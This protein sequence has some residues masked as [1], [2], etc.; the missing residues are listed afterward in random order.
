MTNRP[1]LNALRTFEAAV[2]RG[3]F[4]AAAAELLLTPS[5]VSR[6]IQL[7]EMQLG[8][9]LFRRIGRS[10]AATD[11]GQAYYREI[12]A[13]FGRITAAT[14]NITG[15]G[16]SER[17]SVHSAPS[18]ATQWLLPRL[19]QFVSAHPEL[20]VV[21]WATTPPYDLIAD[22]YDVDIQ[23]G[24]KDTDGLDV[25]SFPAERIVPMC[26]PEVADGIRPIR[27]PEDMMFH[28]LIHSDQCLF[29][30]LDWLER[31][32]GVP[33]DLDRGLHFDRS[34]MSILTAVDGLGV[35]LDSTLIAQKE[36][37]SGRLVKPLGDDGPEIQAHRF[38]C[39]LEKKDL[40]RVVSFRAWLKTAL[41][42]GPS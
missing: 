5:A 16:K 3:S 17:L 23:H 14:A 39:L 20:D 28:T 42:D 15:S 1:S 41:F 21:F 34:F 38:A 11:A 2:R 26:S 18:F 40:P 37:A 4:A 29:R 24:A 19:S 27:S 31:H 36:L 6:Q 10:V 8:A 7:L 35:C 12:H 13:A 9:T 33:L 30:W 22:S 25:M 32:H